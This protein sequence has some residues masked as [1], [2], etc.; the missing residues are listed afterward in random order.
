[1]SK[2]R[3]IVLDPG[4][5]GKDPG[6]QH[7]GLVEKTY[8]LA[9]CKALQ[10]Q[11]KARYTVLLTRTEDVF[12][13]LPS[14]GIFSRDNHA[15]LVLSIHV[16]AG[17]P[18]SRGTMTFHMPQQPHM[19]P[20]GNYLTRIV[21]NPFHVNRRVSY[22]ARN[23]GGE[24]TK[25]LQRPR[26]VL[27]PHVRHADVLLVELFFANSEKEAA[28]GLNQ[29]IMSQLVTAVAQSVDFWNDCRNALDCHSSSDE[30][31]SDINK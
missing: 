25:W 13:D 6:T 16:N 1:M 3:T 5:G 21:P 30:S 10:E 12:I 18:G 24:A 19:L 27:S 26:A 11:L 31:S 14:R 8:N 29:S 7:N 15:D 23:D 2:V 4:H 9:F 28:A 20:V 17:P 22:E